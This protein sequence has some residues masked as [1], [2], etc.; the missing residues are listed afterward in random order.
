MFPAVTWHHVRVGSKSN[1]IFN[2]SHTECQRPTKVGLVVQR[3][4]GCMYQISWQSVQRLLRHCCLKVATNISIP[5][6]TQLVWLKITCE[7]VK[8][9][10]HGYKKPKL[11][12]FFFQ[13]TQ[14]EQWSTMSKSY[15]SRTQT[16]RTS[17]PRVL[18]H[19]NN[20]RLLYCKATMDVDCMELDSRNIK[21][22]NSNDCNNTNNNHTTWVQH[23]SYSM[24]LYDAKDL[25][26]KT[27][28]K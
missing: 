13:G 14:S 23:E 20:V 8:D 2:K 19:Y 3:S 28:V 21:T 5:R 17:S 9:R 12:F 26:T 25:F 16:S 1:H 4:C 15:I 22:L 18:W 10:F 24:L 7:L 6:A 11:T 27:V